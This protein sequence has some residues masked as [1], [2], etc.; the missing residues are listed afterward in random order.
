MDVPP[1]DTGAGADF[2]DLIVL[3]VLPFEAA[4]VRN[5]GP[6]A[7][8]QEDRLCVSFLQHPNHGRTLPIGRLGSHF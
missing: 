1:D 5:I 4:W 6:E 8:L 3:R 7:C 2:Y